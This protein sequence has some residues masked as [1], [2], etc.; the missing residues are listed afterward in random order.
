MYIY[1]NALSLQTQKKS[2]HQTNVFLSMRCELIGFSL[3]VNLSGLL[4]Y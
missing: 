3:M 1:I 2:T 4:E